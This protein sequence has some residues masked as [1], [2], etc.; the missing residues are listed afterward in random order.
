M[1]IQIQ[2]ILVILY[3]ITTALIFHEKTRIWKAMIAGL[4]VVVI[5]QILSTIS[6]RLSF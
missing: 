1:A 3:G 6:F 5:A 2:D 4:V